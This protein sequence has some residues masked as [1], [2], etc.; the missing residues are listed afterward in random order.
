MATIDLSL[1][2]FWVPPN[3]SLYKQHTTSSKSKGSSR[4]KLA[5]P[6]S[7]VDRIHKHNDQLAIT[8]IQHQGDGFITGDQG[9]IRFLE[10]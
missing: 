2:Q 7:K 5:L 4:N 6:Y 9:K 8:T 3:P 1:A 10:I